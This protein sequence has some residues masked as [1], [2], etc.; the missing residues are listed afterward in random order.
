LGLLKNDSFLN[1][2]L[3]FKGK[4]LLLDEKFILN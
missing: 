1:L 4:I 2:N 3:K